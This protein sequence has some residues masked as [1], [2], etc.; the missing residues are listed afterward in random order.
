MMKVTVV[1]AIGIIALL[2]LAW[3]LLCHLNRKSNDQGSEHDP[4]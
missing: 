1:G 2:V 3:L 4:V